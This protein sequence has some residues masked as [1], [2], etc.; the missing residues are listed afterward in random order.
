MFTQKDYEISIAPN[1]NALAPAFTVTIRHLQVSEIQT[2]A[3]KNIPG[4]AITFPGNTIQISITPQA[5]FHEIDSLFRQSY[6]LLKRYNLSSR[7]SD[8]I[9]QAYNTHLRLHNVESAF[10][11]KRGKGQEQDGPRGDMVN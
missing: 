5:P 2:L 1:N 8:E 9:T 10:M 6:S 7:D 11:R 3:A 4:F